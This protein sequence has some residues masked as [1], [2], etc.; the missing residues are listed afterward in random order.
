MAVDSADWARTF[1]ALSAAGMAVSLSGTA[2]RVVN[3][4]VDALRKVLSQAGI[5]ATKSVAASEP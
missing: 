1:E 4:D 3:P 2:V 5:V